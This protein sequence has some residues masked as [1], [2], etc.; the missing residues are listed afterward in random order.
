M[1]DRGNSFSRFKTLQLNR[2]RKVTEL[3]YGMFMFIK[4]TSN[5]NIWSN[6]FAPMNVKPEK[7]DVVFAA[8]KIKFIR[9]DNDVIISAS[10]SFLV[11]SCPYLS[12]MLIFSFIS[13]ISLMISSEVNFSLTMIAI[14][15]LTVGNFEIGDIFL[16]PD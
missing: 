7:Y 10:Y 11:K 13:F 4:D 15:L 14:S 12:S 8:D 9:Q 16:S 5:N 1:N 2:Y 6:T 3:D